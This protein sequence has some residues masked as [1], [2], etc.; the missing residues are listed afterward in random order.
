M[1]PQEKFALVTGC[2]RGGIGEALVAEYTRRGITAIATVLPPEASDHLV[3]AG[4]TFFP[5]DVTVEQSVT[6]LKAAVHELTSGR[7][8]VLVN[9]A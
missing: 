1:A 8:D 6:D 7:L 4:I 9:C 3:N 2:G 5:L